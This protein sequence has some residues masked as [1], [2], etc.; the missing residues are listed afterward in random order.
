MGGGVPREYAPAYRR[1]D[2]FVLRRRIDGRPIT[3]L[4][5][6]RQVGK[7]TLL[8]QLI[9]DLLASGVPPKHVLF[10]S[11]DLPG[12]EL[13][14]ADALNDALRTYEE[15]ILRAPFRSLNEPVYVFLD[16]ITKLPTWHRDLKGWF[17]FR[18]KLRFAVTSS[19]SAELEKGAAESLTGRITTQLLLTWKFV[20]VMSFRT[21]STT[22]N[23]RFLEIRSS[24][25]S[26]V[27]RR[28]AAP[29]FD[30]IKAAMTVS[31]SDQIRLKQ[32][33]EWYLLV[34]GFPELIQ[35]DNLNR[36]AA[37]L[38]DYVKLTL[39]HDLYRFHRV[40]A[41][42]R[43]FEDLLAALASQSGAGLV[44]YRKLAQT[45]HLEERTLIEY[46]DYLESA[47]LI[48]RA[49]FYARTRDTRLRKQRKIY[50][51][52]PGILNLL[53]GRL[54]RSI[55]SNTTDLG[56][57][58]ESVVHGYCK[59]LAFNLSPG[60]PS[61][62][63]YWR[64]RRDR[65]VDAVIEVNRSPLPIEVKF[66]SD[67]TSGLEGMRSFIDEKKPPFGVVVTKDTLRQEGPL[68]FLPLETFLMLA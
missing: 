59:R 12:L 57:L 54:D 37:R 4:A 67:P 34:D 24:F 52:N 11:F 33:L 19:S 39:V 31:R 29:L 10:V 30:G 44:S 50:V 9:Q 47:H 25:L 17:D 28:S 16:E 65:E 2:F 46:L 68:L 8:Y 56:Q 55:F 3:A 43:V 1:R 13:Y 41:T 23:D 64:D 7:T 27:R 36:C 21:G 22:L 26:A 58:V 45:L 62:V 6:P 14:A 20:D 5:G 51:T 32:A 15:R 42:T 40:R 35:L 53:R 49:Q 18:Y 61:A 63:Y 38:D 48:S 66:R 60:Q